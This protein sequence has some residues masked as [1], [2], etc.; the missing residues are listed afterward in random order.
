VASFLSRL[1]GRAPAAPEPERPAE[2]GL[3]D[4]R[5][6]IRADVFAGFADEDVILRQAGD[7]FE[8]E[9]DPAVVRREAPAMLREALAEYARASAD[10]PAVTD[11]DRLD[12]AFAALEEGGIVA[13]QN[14]ACC[15]SCGS[16]EIWDEM[17]GEGTVPVR[18]YTFYHEQDTE[19]AV[20]GNGVYLAYGAVEEGEAASLVV[21]R[22]VVARLE[23]AGLSPEWNGSIDRRIAVPLNWKR[24]RV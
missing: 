21:A 13:R 2:T 12:A 15:M 19:A 10:W 17:E 7:S 8:G 5:A 24:R 23:A 1:F 18:G 11:C 20:E 16:A 14:F 22:E 4:L 6:W 9:I 3:E